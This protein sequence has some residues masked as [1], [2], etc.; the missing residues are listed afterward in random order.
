[1]QMNK[2]FWTRTDVGAFIY[3]ALDSLSKPHEGVVNESPYVFIT[4]LIRQC[5]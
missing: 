4:T 1:M 2:L 5:S 3:Y